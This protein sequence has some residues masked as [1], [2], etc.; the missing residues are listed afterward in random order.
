[1]AY[2]WDNARKPLQATYTGPMAFI[3]QL[4]ICE[5]AG[6]LGGTHGGQTGRQRGVL[7]LGSRVEHSPK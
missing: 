5:H 4:E 7:L 2:G 1:M 6:E 3:W